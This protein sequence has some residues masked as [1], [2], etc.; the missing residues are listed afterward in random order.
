ML[1]QSTEAALNIGWDVL[2][3]LILLA[4]L[5]LLS[6]PIWIALGLSALLMLWQTNVLPLSLLGESLFSGVNHYALIA[7]P[8]YLLTGDAL[9]RTGL[10]VKL[11][12]FAEA[13]MG[14]L[15]SGM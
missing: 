11:L 3:S 10:S 8:L 12:N 1:Y 5:F 13:T 6:V 9:V 15:R 7:I 2:G 4:V 14:S